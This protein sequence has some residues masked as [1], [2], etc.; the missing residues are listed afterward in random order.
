MRRYGV[1]QSKIP[2]D[3]LNAISETY[4]DFENRE[5]RQNLIIEIND[6]ELTLKNKQ[7]NEILES[8][9]GYVSWIDSDLNYVGMNRNLEN[10]IGVEDKGLMGK[11]IADESPQHFQKLIPI[12]EAFRGSEKVSDQCSYSANYGVGEKFFNVYLQK[13][14]EGSKIIINSIDVTENVLL[15]RQLVSEVKRKLHKERLVLLGEITAGVAHEINNPMTVVLG[16]SRA[17]LRKYKG[18][19]KVVG[20]EETPDLIE[21]VEKIITMA[22]RVSKIVQSLKLLSRD[23]DK[24]DFEMENLE[25][26]IIPA[27]D[28]S[29]DKLKLHDVKLTIDKYEDISIKCRAGELTQVLFNLI[30]NAIEAIKN[31]EEKWISIDIKVTKLNYEIRVTD[32][33]KGVPLE[34]QDKLFSPF[35]TTKPV[36]DGTGLGLSICKKI[37]E[38]HKGNISIDNKCINTCFIVSLKI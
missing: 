26:I 30:N 34:I 38:N 9:P 11:N 3:L 5:E 29:N 1:D 35:F 4:N 17:I 37:I 12:V 15:Q 20:P 27:I 23:T 25:R 18:K 32:S 28:L 10:L 22:N 36:G 2:S 8:L 13:I 24:D 14:S 6:E 19:N 7:V 21:R 31:L 16:Q 33:G